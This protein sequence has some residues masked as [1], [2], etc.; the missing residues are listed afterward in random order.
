M[1]S[2][3]DA[4]LDCLFCEIASG[5][6]PSH[7]VYETDSVLAFLD[8]HPIRPGHTQIIPREHHAYYDDLP[9]SLAL[10]VFQVGQRLA[11]VLR[12]L[13]NVQRVGFLFTGGD[14]AHAHAHVVP[15]VETTDITSRRYIAEDP[16]TFRSTPRVP[17]S[18][19]TKTAEMIRHVLDGHA[20]A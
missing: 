16:L 6:A 10:E 11:P 3:R 2:T 1:P 8:I 20:R 17:D 4:A 14:V 18:E 9:S 7:L 5:R 15:I 13:F 19:L 12:S